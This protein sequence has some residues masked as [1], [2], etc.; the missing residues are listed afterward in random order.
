MDLHSYLLRVSILLISISCATKN[1]S[2][3]FFTFDDFP[4]KKELKGEKFTYDEILVPS[5]ILF[6]NGKL[7]ISDRSGLAILH[8]INASSMNYEQE[9]G[10]IG[11]GPGELPGIWDLDPGTEED[12]FWVYSNTG[13]L[14][15]SYKLLGDNKLYTDVVKQTDSW[16]FATKLRI[17][18]YKT[19]IGPMIEGEAKY[20]IYDSL[21][22]VIKTIGLWSDA[23]PELSYNPRLIADLHQGGFTGNHKN[24]IYV[25]PFIDFD[26]IEILNIRNN[27]QKIITGPINYFPHYEVVSSQGQEIVHIPESEE[28]LYTYNAAF[29]GEEYIYLGFM[30]KSNKQMRKGEFIKDIFVLDLEGK[31]I[32]HFLLDEYVLDISVNE[33]QR[34]I[35]GISVGEEP[36][37]LVFEY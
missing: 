25:F 8:R 9:I 7:I 4:E 15:A 5:R 28:K 10:Q 11:W 14:F 13:K 18:D 30:G 23:I 20:T 2:D 12:S 35:Y 31:P 19:F 17:V 37:I 22:N 16:I 26:K 6:K 1:P 27:S 32:T 24:G 29:V 3:N 36:G 33:E 21:G 34:K